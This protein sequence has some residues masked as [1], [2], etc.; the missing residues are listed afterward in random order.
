MKTIVLTGGGTGG[1]IIPHLSLIPLIKKDFKN[2]VYIGTKNGLEFDI[3]SK[4]QGINFKSISAVKL[5]RDKKLENLLLPFKLV[6]SICQAKKILKEIKPSI[7]L[8]KGGF[9]SVPVCIAGK[10]LKIPVVS[11]ESDLSIG[12]ANKIIYKTCSSFCTSFEDT[13]KNLK[14]AVFT[15][16]P[17]RPELFLGNKQIAYNK[18]KVSQNKPT[19]LI[20]GGSTGALTLNNKI[21]EALPELLKTYNVI[22]IV[23]KNKGDKSKTF[24]DYCQLEYC[25]NI[26]DILAITDIV[27]S[28]AGSNAIFEF[29]ALKKPMI[30]IP[31]PKNASRGDQIENALYFENKGFS[32]TILQENLTK[33]FLLK[34]IK[35][36]E[37]N[38]NFY[39]S[40]MSKNLENLNGAKNI[41]SQILKFA[42][43]NN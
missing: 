5:Q 29:L 2:I 13:S 38:K 1:H 36:I 37:K 12:L 41:Y 33:E 25:Q 42:K 9:V 18:T 23:G 24:K 30:L 43:P 6:S 31:L 35:E 17:I 34:A 39:I 14:K 8:S 20:I 28:R 4:K 16:S 22:H 21:Y 19:I 7:I 32:K 3:M 40:N 10:L 27:I 11:H 26:Q 15:G